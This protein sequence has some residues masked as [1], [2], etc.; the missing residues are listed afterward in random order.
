MKTR[1][2]GTANI[3]LNPAEK[4]EISAY[5]LSKDE[6][7]FINLILR[8]HASNDGILDG[9]DVD[10]NLLTESSDAQLRNEFS[11]QA[12]MLDAAMT[13][14]DASSFSGQ[15]TLEQAALEC[16]KLARALVGQL[17]G[18][19]MSNEAPSAG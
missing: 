8:E 5:E 11:N 12:R 17:M 6:Y 10:A 7:A 19:P 15:E 3:L 2:T 9:Q 1:Y 4:P 13:L 18:Q 14:I 16:L